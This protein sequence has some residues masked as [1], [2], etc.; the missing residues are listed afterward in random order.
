MITRKLGD[1]NIDLSV[2]GLGTWAIGGSGW[3][4]GWGIQDDKDSIDTIL[5]ALELGINWIDTAPIYGLG[6]SEIIVGKALKMRDKEKIFISTKCGLIGDDSGH[7][8]QYLKKESIVQELDASLKRL[9]IERIDLYQIHWPN[10]VNEIFEAFETLNE[11]K[12]KGKIRYAGV[13][14]F[15]VKQMDA[16][17]KAGK[18]SFLQTPY[19]IIN[20]RI[21]N[22]IIDYCAQNKMGIVSYSPMQ[23]GLLTEKASLDWIKSLKEDDWRKT[24]SSFFKEPQVNFTLDLNK[25]LKAFAESRGYSISNLA[26]SWILRKNEITSVIA[27]ARKPIQIE[28]TV[29]SSK[30]ILTNE[31]ITEID[32][33]LAEYTNHLKTLS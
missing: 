32:F 4:Y 3:D 13:S 11:L 20:R 30:W 10:P 8:S 23:C 22:E 29:K 19:S 24:K 21:E 12:Q 5:K 27:G 17:K 16:I 14:N 25:K 6:H 15:S 31:D 28:E 26:I 9:N 33:Y 2:I 1:S 7:V 18:I